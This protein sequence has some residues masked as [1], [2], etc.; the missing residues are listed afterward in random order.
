MKQEPN[1]EKIIYFIKNIFL[2][3][4]YFRE[5]NQSLNEKE[6]IFFFRVLMNLGIW[7]EPI[8]DMRYT[9]DLNYTIL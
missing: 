2:Q 3:T 4:N 1:P 6:S 9:I 8:T 5:T 7:M